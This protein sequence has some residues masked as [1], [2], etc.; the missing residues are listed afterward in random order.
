MSRQTPPGGPSVNPRSGIFHNLI[1][2]TI[3]RLDPCA[4]RGSRAGGRHVTRAC[5]DSSGHA[6]S[7]RPLLL[8]PSRGTP[9]GTSTGIRPAMVATRAETRYL[10]QWKT[11]RH[12]L[13]VR[14]ACNN[15]SSDAVS[16]LGQRRLPRI[17]SIRPICMSWRHQNG[18][19]RRFFTSPKT[20]GQQQMRGYQFNSKCIIPLIITSASGIRSTGWKY[21]GCHI[22]CTSLGNVIKHVDVNTVVQSQRQYLVTLQE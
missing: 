19:H 11:N 8:W 13:T 22:H 1:W 17:E 7:G 6:G 16:I 4:A 10:Y 12:V 14:S 2:H 3:N 20:I 5:R 15:Q 18:R 9:G 21:V